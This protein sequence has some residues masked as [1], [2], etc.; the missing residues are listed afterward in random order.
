[1][2]WACHP[3]ASVVYIVVVACGTICIVLARIGC[4]WPH[5]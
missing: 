1:M 3:A 5:R 4:G 2:G